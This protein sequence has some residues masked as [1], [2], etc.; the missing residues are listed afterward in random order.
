MKYICLGFIEKGKF[1]RMPDD[2]QKAMLDECFEYD[3]RLRT[4]GFSPREKL[5]SLRIRL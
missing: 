5:F 2:A 3:D 1:E 4:N